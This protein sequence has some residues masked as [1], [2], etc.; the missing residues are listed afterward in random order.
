[1]HG[2]VPSRAP[3]R[4]RLLVL[5]LAAT[6]V[7]G[8]STPA[9]AAWSVNGN[10]LT[11][12]TGMQDIPLAAPDGQ[13]GAYVV[14]LDSRAGNV[15]LYAQHVS[16]TGAIAPGWPADG[17]ALCTHASTQ[18]DPAIASDGVGGAYLVWADPRTGSSD[19]Y[20][21]RLVSGGLAPGW[22]ADGRGV[23]TAA[24]EQLNPV[25]VGDG[26][27]GALVAWSD[28]RGSSEDVYVQ[29]LLAGGTVDGAWAANGALLSGAAQQQ[30][31]PTIVSDGSGGALV[32]WEDGR[33][34]GALTS[35]KDL[36]AG[37]MT[38]LGLPDTAWTVNG[39]L[40]ALVPGFDQVSP[41]A[42]SD[43]N[44]GAIVTWLDARNGTSDL[45]AMRI[46]ADG[47]LAPGWTADG[48][49]VVNTVGEQARPVLVTD[50]AGGA[51]IAW[52]DG[53]DTSSFPT[54]TD[55]FAL[56]LLANGT[57]APGWPVNGVDLTV[58]ADRQDDPAI[59]TDGV[60]GALLA[61]KDGRPGAEIYA[62]HVRSD[63]TRAPGWPGDGLAICTATSE[64][65]EPTIVSDGSGG[66]VCAWEDY[67]NGLANH[68]IYA[69][70][71]FGS[72]QVGP[73]VGVGDAPL[74]GAALALAFAGA[75]PARGEARFA[76]TLPAI[77]GARATVFNP[78]G[79]RVAV[80][81]SGEARPAGRQLVTW[82][83]HDTA[84]RAAPPGL[85]ALEVIAGT[86]RAALRF[87]FL[88]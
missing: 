69:Q 22:P 72:G 30:A 66:A 81:W 50:G 20:A 70:R 53:R 88:P 82:D 33:N 24:G 27:G 21:L 54:N 18:N 87:V 84:G 55:I 19:I 5:A 71:F 28:L 1:M 34:G 49:E 58:Q 78:A 43:L 13:G 8:R 46:L 59:C 73:T 17:L 42:V 44:G 35:Q 77:D 6:L 31:F 83:G 47:T 76:I 64:Q 15:D 40:L 68:D 80:L 36:F 23:C 29:H 3:R 39:E 10:P 63:G 85:Y 14:W 25:V 41:Q 11:L 37:H 79:R 32:A 57:R 52:Q 7:A 12:A 60:G 2:R 9:L 48:V 62:Q 65:I 56:R 75:H 26:A 67:R 4:A 61:W 16:A 38:A 86:R 51:I 74:P 45:Y